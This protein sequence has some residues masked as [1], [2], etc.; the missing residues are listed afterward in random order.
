MKVRRNLGIIFKNFIKLSLTS[1][2]IVDKINEQLKISLPEGVQSLKPEDVTP[3]AT[4]DRI[5]FGVTAF[6]DVYAKQKKNLSGDEL[7]DSFVSEVTR[8]VGQGYEDAFKFL[9]ELAHSKSKA[10]RK[11]LKKQDP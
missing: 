2:E 7:V 11:E 1:K 8:G 4:A 6:F 10:C 9:K 3:E 5:V